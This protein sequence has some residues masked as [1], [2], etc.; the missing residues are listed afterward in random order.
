MITILKTD[1]SN[2]TAEAKKIE[3]GCWIHL[4]DPDADEIEKTLECTGL[5]EDFIKAALDREESSRLEVEDDRILV[6]LDI[7]I[8]DVVGTTSRYFTIPLGIVL[9]DDFIVTVSIQENN[10]INDFFEQKVKTFYTY[11]KSRFILQILLRIAKYYLSFLKQI[12]K[13]TKIIEDEL[14]RSLR[15]KELFDMLAL[16]KSLVYFSTSLKSNQLTLEKMLKLN[17][18]KKYPEDADLLEDVIIENKQ[19][20]EMSGIY[21]NIIQGTM[22]A[23]ASIIS[24]NLNV[25]MKILTS[26][27]IVLA[28]PTIIASLF[29]MNVPLPW[30]D[31]PLAFIFIIIITIVLCAGVIVILIRK[32]L[33]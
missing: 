17:I 24:N 29:G 2:K 32:R 6:L 11:K 1:E 12:E 31:L 14:H 22:T 19:A 3:K 20:I 9:N 33:L 18:M 8:M 7:P 10:I 16:E 23:F 21:S 5:E 30:G 26:I 25:V 4:N 28:V 13:S 15:N 27:T